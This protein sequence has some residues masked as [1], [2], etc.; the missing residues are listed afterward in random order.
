MEAAGRRSGRGL[1]RYLIVQV[2]ER[3]E[4]RV[5]P[6]TV[7]M[8]PVRLVNARPTTLP[9]KPKLYHCGGDAGPSASGVDVAMALSV[10]ASG[11]GANAGADT[12]VAR[13]VAEPQPAE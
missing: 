1:G 6:Y 3:A 9:E 11:V 12:P 4:I 8:M 7:T 2:A 5:E 13:S 10:S